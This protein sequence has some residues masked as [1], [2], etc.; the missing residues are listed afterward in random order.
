MLVSGAVFGTRPL[1][2]VIRS[3]NPSETAHALML[4][5]PAAGLAAEAV[6]AEALL[7]SSFLCKG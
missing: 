1:S 6:R 2:G 3:W 7:L 5:T 4:N